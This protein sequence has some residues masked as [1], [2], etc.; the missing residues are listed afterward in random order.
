MEIAPVVPTEFASG[1]HLDAA[2]CSIE[3]RMPTGSQLAMLER[4]LGKIESSVDELSRARGVLLESAEKALYALEATVV[5]LKS[6][7]GLFGLN[8]PSLRDALCQDFQAGTRLWCPS[9]LGTIGDG[10]WEKCEFDRFLRNR[11]FKPIKPPKPSIDGLIV[12]MRGWSS[13]VLSKQIQGKNTNSLRIYTQELFVFGIILGRDPYDV[14]EQKVI[15]EV[16]ERHPAIQF[17]LNNDF[18]WPWK[19]GEFKPAGAHMNKLTPS[20]ALALV[21]GPN[22]LSRPE[23]QRRLW[24]YIKKHKLQDTQQRR[25]INADEKLKQIFGLSQ[26]SIFELGV[27]IGGHLK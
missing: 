24:D 6:Q 19:V 25:M 12:G 3:E 23:A 27:L 2:K 10:P 22:P 16:A 9:H 7:S 14:L 4:Q 18:A 1:T 20:A 13:E 8:L 15:E 21:V 5:D 26:V 11:M 17:I